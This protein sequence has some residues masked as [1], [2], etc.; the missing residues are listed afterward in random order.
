MRMIL[1]L[2]L[3][4]YLVCALYFPVLG[5]GMAFFFLLGRIRDATHLD[6]QFAIPL[7]LLALAMLALAIWRCIHV[8]RR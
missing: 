4:P 3:F 6:Y 5:C 1:L 8:L 7:L 2:F